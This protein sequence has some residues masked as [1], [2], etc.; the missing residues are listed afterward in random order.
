MVL[1]VTA[2]NVY[3]NR[4][5]SSG[6]FVYRSSQIGWKQARPIDRLLA[7]SRSIQ[8]TTSLNTS[9]IDVGDASNLSHAPSGVLDPVV[10]AVRNKSYDKLRGM[11]NEAGLGV[12]IVEYRQAR[13]MFATRGVQFLEIGSL[14]ARGKFVTAGKKLGCNFYNGKP[15]RAARRNGW[16][17]PDFTKKTNISAS[18]LWLEWHFGL[19]PLI[20][21][22]QD[23]AKVLTEPLPSSRIRG[24][25]EQFVRYSTYVTDPANPGSFTS[26]SWVTR[27]RFRQG[28]EIAITNP[29]LALAN[30]LGVLNPA[31]LAWEIVPFSFVVDWVVNVGDWLQGFTDFAGMTLQ[32]PFN[33]GHYWSYHNYTKVLK[34][35][36]TSNTYIGTRNGKVIT[37]QRQLGLTGVSLAVRPLKLPS[38]S[39]A[40]TIWSLASQIL[41]RK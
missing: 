20:G 9:Q 2:R 7:Y 13:D 18:N 21:D 1:P 4:T 22:C 31:S 32:Y 28:T 5:N 19:S 3:V 39:R 35:W 11:V 17:L 8:E 34:P 6:K 40:A 37:A 26:E 12:N 38:L 10:T 23:A 33:T 27:C 36:G 25:T 41:Q 29:N 24:S 14:L 16:I 30:Q 15:P